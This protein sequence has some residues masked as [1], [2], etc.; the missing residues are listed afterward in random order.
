MTISG[1]SCADKPAGGESPRCLRLPRLTPGRSPL[2]AR[3]WPG[4]LHVRGATRSSFQCQSRL[5][6]PTAIETIREKAGTRS[7][8][9]GYTLPMTLIIGMS[10]P[11]GIYLCVDYRITNSRTRELT[12]ERAI[13]FLDIRYPPQDAGGPKVLLGF[14]GLAELPDGTPMLDW[15]RQTLRGESEVIDQ[16]MAHL[17][18]RL[19]RDI[20]PLRQELTISLLVIEPYRRLLGAFTNRRIP[21]PGQDPI[22]PGFQYSMTRLTD[23]TIFAHGSGAD[24]LVR[25]GHFARLQPHLG[26]VPRKPMNHMKLLASMNRRV[27]EKDRT[28]SAFSQVSFINAGDR[29]GGPTS[30][31]FVERGESVPF[32]M[33]L[34]ITGIDT[35]EWMRDFVRN[36][37]AFFRGEIDAMPED[38]AEK[39]EKQIKRRS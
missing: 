1:M 29:F 19:N 5:D 25:D 6:T 37:E 14:S 10:K 21:P 16:S 7:V 24:R 34:I 17:R 13:K 36:S 28:V 26:T 9:R 30:H 3:S 12:H 18:K 31:V 23:W 15:I 39:M 2:L 4:Q 35:T 8:D 32:E 27:A 22:M 33:P 38:S 20:A 11:E